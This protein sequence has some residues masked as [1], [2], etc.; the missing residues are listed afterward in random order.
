MW[1]RLTCRKKPHTVRGT[2]SIDSQ[3]VTWSMCAS[4]AWWCTCDTEFGTSGG[5]WSQCLDNEVKHHCQPHTESGAPVSAFPGA[6]QGQK[7][8]QQ[9]YKPGDLF[10]ANKDMGIT[11]CHCHQVNLKLHLSNCRHLKLQ[12]KIWTA[13]VVSRLC[14]PC[15]DSC[16]TCAS[17]I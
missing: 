2:F 10:H 15:G 1:R 7:A 16:I 11:H 4:I 5:S 12:K 13:I 6:T 3:A 17:I 8:L 9:P 14:L